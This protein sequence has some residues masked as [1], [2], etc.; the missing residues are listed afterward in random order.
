MMRKLEK[1]L[2]RSVIESEKLRKKNVK[3]FVANLNRFLEKHIPKIAKLPDGADA[4]EAASVLGGL[5]SSLQ[6]EGLGSVVKEIR[7]SYADELSYLATRFQISGFETS[8]S[9]FNRATV[10]AL[11][12]N[13]TKRVTK[14]ISPYID[15]VSSTLIRA[16]VG[17]QKPDVSALLDGVTGVLESQLETEVN[18]MLSSF[19]Q[20]VSNNRAEELGFDLYIYIGPEDKITR[21][22]CESVLIEKSPPIYS[23]KEIDD[24][25]NHPDLDSGLDV[26][27]YR[28]GY[29][30][31]HRWIGISKEDALAMGW[32]E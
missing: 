14:L 18:T 2:Q 29:N 15:D 26:F 31:R 19:S 25:N 1:Q 28:G 30:C 7:T 11:I 16:V 20:T 24:L 5:Q 23:R 4:L 9:D 3:L 13:D 21:D 32:K 6:A 22:F 8:L 17:G 27:T 10:K 12:N